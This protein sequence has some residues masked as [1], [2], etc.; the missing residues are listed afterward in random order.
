[1]LLINPCL[2]TQGK[3]YPYIIAALF[4]KVLI[5]SSLSL[6]FFSV[7]NVDRFPIIFATFFLKK[8]SI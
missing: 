7:L 5:L 6:Y 1:M 8:R 3:V 4:I 2:K